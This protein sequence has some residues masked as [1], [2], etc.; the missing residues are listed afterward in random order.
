M[1]QQATTMLSFNFVAAMF[2][3]AVGAPK[4][5]IRFAPIVL[6]DISKTIM[7]LLPP[8]LSPSFFYA[9]SPGISPPRFPEVD[10]QKHSLRELLQDLGRWGSL[11]ERLDTQPS[12]Q[13]PVPHGG[14]AGICGCN[15]LECR[16]VLSL[17]VLLRQM[18]G[19]DM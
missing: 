5:T 2:A 11:T 10:I 19:S 15:L 3:L 14:V 17:G 12:N 13:M 6:P 7:Q 8:G 1:L 16:S 4:H 18:W 9:M